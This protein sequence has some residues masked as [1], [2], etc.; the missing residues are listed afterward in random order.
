MLKL[1]QE[2]RFLNPR[3]NLNLYSLFLVGWVE[4][5]KPFDYAVTERQSK[6]R[7]HPTQRWCCWVLLSL[8]PTYNLNLSLLICVHLLQERFNI[9]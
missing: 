7:D 1:W 5:T 6:C 3:D 9:S 8:N 4:A 2:T